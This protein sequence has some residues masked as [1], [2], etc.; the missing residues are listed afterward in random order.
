MF[1][2]AGPYTAG[3]LDPV[4]SVASDLPLAVQLVTFEPDDGYGNAEEGALTIDVPDVVF[5]IADD[6]SFLLCHIQ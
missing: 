1:V 2:G 3:A 5:K 4:R 6:V